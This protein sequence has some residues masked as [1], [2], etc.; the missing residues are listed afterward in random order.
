MSEINPYY[1]KTFERHE[2]DKL[3]VERGEAPHL[4]FNRKLGLSYVVIIENLKHSK[5]KLAAQNIKLEVWQ[6][7]LI[8]I[9]FGWERQRDDGSWVRRFRIAF[10]FLPRKNG[11]TLLASGM[12]VADMIVR[13]E[14]GGEICF[15]ATKRDQAKLSYN[16]AKYM[17]ENNTDLKK[18]TKESY[19]KTKFDKF[20]TE[21]YTL[22]RDSDTQD[23]LNI[24][25]GLAD[26]RHAHKDNGLW[27]VVK[28]SQMARREPFML[29]ITTAGFNIASPAYSDYEYAKKVMEG[30]IED[31]TYFAFIAE[32]PKKPDNDPHWYF[33]E[34]VWKAANP[35]FGISVDPEDF[36][37]AAKEAYERP[38]K[39]NNFLVKY[40]NVWTTSSESY[41]PLAKWE[42]C[43]GDVDVS[44]NIIMGLDMSIGDDF[45][46]MTIVREIDGVYHIK[47]YFYMP[48]ERV[49]DR[50]RELRAPLVSWVN[51]GY[52]TA[53]PGSTIDEEYII[54][55]IVPTLDK[56]EAF[57]YDPWKAR[58]IINNLEN[59]EGYENCIP[60]VQ[61]FKTLSEPTSFFL[62]L[63]KDGKIVHDG[64]PVMTW[65]V[66]NLAILTDAAG[67]IKPDKTDY[68]KKIDGVAAVINTFA[69]LI[70]NLQSDK[71][72]VYEE[73]GMRSL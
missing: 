16:A 51:Q 61:G 3:R 36:A 1:L 42:E 57:C 12:A 32:A 47:P 62:K 38:E 27:D 43:K 48:K 53:T 31:D 28:S 9:L 67:N 39:L 15:F 54:N 4:R 29:S 64:N 58:R 69:Y 41:I 11:K 18:H 68:N 55:D 35:N 20:D 21:L 24:S 34:E 30:V 33:K 59:E 8:V 5:G 49:A 6:K 13:P 71:S 52:I 7:K 50:E 14:I 63:V 2:A 46:S 25:F 19:G 10:I 56:T 37:N 65:M 22:G 70:H 26:E 23:G 72:S 40:L 73:R 17:L 45:T 66:S 44:E 60:I